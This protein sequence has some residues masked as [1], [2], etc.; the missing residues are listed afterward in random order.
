MSGKR[1]M[2]QDEGWLRENYIQKGRSQR[3]IAAEIGCSQSTISRWLDE[4]GI[5]TRRSEQDAPQQL[6]SCEWLQRK[7][8]KDLC[9][10]RDI[11][12]EL[13]C[14]DTTVLR[15]LN[16]HG[17]QTRKPNPEVPEKLEDPEWL[18]EEYNKKQ[19][20]ITE[21]ARE[22]DCSRKV[23]WTRLNKHDI[24]SRGFANC[25]CNHYNW[26]GGKTSYG[27]GWNERKRRQVRER[28]GYKCQD[29]RCSIE[30]KQH[31][32]ENDERLHVHHLRKARDV[33]D[34]QIRNSPENLITLCR[35]C[36]KRWEV[37]SEI[38]L[39]P[40]VCGINTNASIRESH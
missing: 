4:Y 18:R 19:R 10:L 36:H 14:H 21:I 13:G 30:Q 2:L 28:D 7:Y 37:M 26:G 16:K 12:E 31:I 29:P 38:G 6:K 20:S 34:D 33:D 3:E 25:G 9:S 5:Q 15:W 11:A 8:I 40:Q 1:Q 22:I 23:V 27:E 39:V 17:I 32:K 24:E 35:D